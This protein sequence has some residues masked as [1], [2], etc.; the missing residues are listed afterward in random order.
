MPWGASPSPRPDGDE[1][2]LFGF[3]FADDAEWTDLDIRP[4]RYIG[5]EPRRPARSPG[6]ETAV[7]IQPKA[8][9]HRSCC[10]VP[11]RELPERAGF[12]QTPLFITL[13]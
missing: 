3:E 10:D 7:H 1:P 11:E 8:D 5:E 12:D 4:P 13:T 9:V 6:R 2:V